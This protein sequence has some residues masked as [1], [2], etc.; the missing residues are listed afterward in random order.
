MSANTSD[1]N[2][3]CFEVDNI[4]VANNDWLFYFFATL[5]TNCNYTND[6]NTSKPEWEENTLHTKNFLK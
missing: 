6:C 1:N 4:G 5:T 2:L 3:T